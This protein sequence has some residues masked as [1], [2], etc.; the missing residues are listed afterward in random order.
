MVICSRKDKIDSLLSWAMSSSQDLPSFYESSALVKG[1]DPGRH[2]KQALLQGSGFISIVKRY[3]NNALANIILS[4][5]AVMKKNGVELEGEKLL[6]KDFKLAFILF[7]RLNS[8]CEDV[9]KFMRDRYQI[10]EVA[11]LC[12][13]YISIAAGYRIN[14]SINIGEMDNNTLCS[15]LNAAT[16]KAKQMFQRESKLRAIK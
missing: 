13:C 10:R 11:A 6:T 12:K 9:V 2:S 7:Q 1:G 3:A 8:S 4:D 14:E 5:L 15:L 16:L